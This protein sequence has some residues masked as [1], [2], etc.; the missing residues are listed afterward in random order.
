MLR[1]SENFFFKHTYIVTVYLHHL[2]FSCIIELYVEYLGSLCI[3]SFYWL[4][5]VAL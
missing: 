2:S 1:V 4:Q 3:R 5:T